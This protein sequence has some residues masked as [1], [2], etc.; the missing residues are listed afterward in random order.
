MPRHLASR[1]C[2][3]PG[4]CLAVRVPVG[5][6]CPRRHARPAVRGWRDR[7]GPVAAWTQGHTRCGPAVRARA[8]DQADHH[9][10]GCCRR[11]GVR[12][13]LLALRRRVR[14]RPRTAERARVARTEFHNRRRVRAPR[15]GGQR[16]QPALAAAQR[17][18]RGHIRLPAPDRRD[19]RHVV[20]PACAGWQ[21][22]THCPVRADLAPGRTQRGQ[23][24]QQRQLSDRAHTRAG[25]GAALRLACAAGAVRR[26]W[27][28]AGGRPVR[29]AAALAEYVRHELPG[30]E[31]AWP[32]P[33]AG[34]RRHRRPPRRP[35][36]LRARRG[37][38]RTGRFRCAQWPACVR[39]AD[40]LARRAA[41]RP[42]A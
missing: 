35:G 24:R 4:S 2:R 36:P 23:R 33:D 38:R 31:R 19:G 32:H 39:A 16:L 40:R 34:R 14:G 41:A 11:S 26:R 10:G 17:D 29:A 30:R 22:L 3:R 15:A 1:G 28:D 6:V 12:A 5:G 25:A 8:V 7:G 13:A 20:A 42:L 27:P 18:L 9:H 21:A 37:H